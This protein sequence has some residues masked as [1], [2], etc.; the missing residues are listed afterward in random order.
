MCATNMTGG[1]AEEIVVKVRHSGK[2]VPDEKR[3]LF[4]S[5][6]YIPGLE[7]RTAYERNTKRERR[8]GSEPLLPP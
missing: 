1:T 7:V 8:G 6:S 2:V 5:L 4:L 3:W